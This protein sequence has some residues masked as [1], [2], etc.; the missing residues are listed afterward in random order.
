MKSISILIPCFNEAESI[1]LLFDELKNICCSLV[2]IQ[3]RLIFVDDGSYD[4]TGSIL[5]ALLEQSDWCVG[6]VIN[7][8]RNF[9]KEA[10]LICGLDHCSSD[11]C[12]I[13]DADLQH[14]PTKIPEMVSL[15]QT[16]YSVVS[17]KRRL[18]HN[19]YSLLAQIPS[20]LF[21]RCFK[22]F[23]NLDIS[24]DSSD[25][26]LLDR[27]PYESIRNCREVVRFS[28]GFFAWTGFSHVE[29]LYDQPSRKYGTSKWGSWR[30][31]NYALDGIFNFST[32][33]L[34]IW[35][36]IGL[37]V[38]IISFCLATR[39]LLLVLYFGNNVPGYASIFLAITFL[40]GVQL[41]GIGVIGEYVGRVFMETKSRPLY[42]VRSIYTK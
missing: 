3:W 22:T 4:N 2:N 18:E 30:L 13:M 33:P 24:L 41:V 25:F 27:A 37:L 15:W 28:K 20:R 16:G 1:E 11:A 34:R 21:Y 32:I 17:A 19:N 42:L 23:S 6:N 9:G 36:Y 31:W 40:G 12:I 14:P 7:L 35:S 8:S 29:I 38:I 10:A 39:E 5:E 26:R